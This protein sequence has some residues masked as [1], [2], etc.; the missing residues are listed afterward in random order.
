MGKHIST[1]ERKEASM[2]QRDARPIGGVYHLGQQIT[3]GGM[4]TTYTAY[5]RNTNDV[6]GLHVIEV[7][8]PGQLQNAQPHFQILDKRRKIQSPHVL[9]LHDWGIDL[10]RIYIAT[11]PPRGVTLQHV[12]DNENIDIRRAIDLTRQIAIGLNV[13]HEQG[14]SGLDLRPQLIT[15][16]TIGVT[17][18]VQIDDIGLRN[19][20]LSLGYLSSQRNDDIG[21]LDPRYAPP[22]YITRGPVGLW[23][24]IY[25]SGLLLFALVTGRLPFIGRTPAETGMMQNTAPVP[26]M[27]GYQHETPEALQGL[28]EQA[29]QKN[30]G[31]RFLHTQ[32]FINALNNVEMP[33]P[34]LE[35]REAIARAP[36]IDLTKEMQPVK[37]DVTLVATQLADKA[38]LSAPLSESSLPNV[39]N[40]EG[41]YAYLAYERKGEETRRFPITG[42]NIIVGRLDPKRGVN[43]DVDLS[44]LDLTMTISRQHARIR[45]EGTFFYV[46]D[47]KSRNKTRLGELVLTPLKAELLQHGDQLQFGNVS[48]KFEVPGMTD[49]PR[50]KIRPQT[51]V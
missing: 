44:A 18:R 31:R 33:T 37:Q 14:I 12:F 47:L 32:A 19:L 51:S 4:L 30:Y 41:A 6:V 2:P 48:L 15:V 28:V 13:L 11:D 40:E 8:T 45:F 24:D 25:Q 35:L 34:N 38:G 3:A 49:T 26:T 36:S 27:K 10:N 21:Y 17:D 9:R 39:P 1:S 42:R 23:S 46:E 50:V 43:P 22:E 16:D 29:M 7:Q 5:N 20:L